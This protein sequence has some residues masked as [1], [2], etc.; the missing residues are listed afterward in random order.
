[1]NYVIQKSEQVNTLRKVDERIE[2]IEEE[3]TTNGVF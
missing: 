3:A 1:M 2:G